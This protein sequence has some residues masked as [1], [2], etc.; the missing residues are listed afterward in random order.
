MAI[1]ATIRVVY[2]SLSAMAASRPA[3]LFG[4]Q[5][6]QPVV[7]ELRLTVEDELFVATL[8]RRRELRLL[9]LTELLEEGGYRV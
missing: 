3:A 6:L 8:V 9:D 1:L 5:D 4:S 7:H 2:I